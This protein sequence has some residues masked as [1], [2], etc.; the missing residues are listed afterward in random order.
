[1]LT[2]QTSGYGHGRAVVHADRGLRERHGAEEGV[3]LLGGQ[4][5]AR[6]RVP[7]LPRGHLHGGL[8]AGHLL[9]AHQP[10]VVV[11][12]AGQGQSVA[13]DGVGDETGRQVVV[14]LVEGVEDRGH[15]VAGQVGHERVQRVVIEPVEERADPVHRAEVA[16]EL[17]APGLPALERQRGVARVRA[18][19][20][21][22]SKRVAAGPAE[23]RFE[24]Q[25]V[26]EHDDAEAGG[27]KDVVHAAEEP[28]ADHGVEALAVVVDH[29][30]EV[31][32]VVLPALE[33]RLEHIALVE[34]GV[35]QHRDH[36]AGRRGRGRR[37]HQADV[38]LHERGEERHRHP[39]AHRPGGEV[40]AGDV[41]RAR[42][43]RLGAAE[44]AELLEV[45]ARLAPEEVLD[46]VVD[47]ARV[48]LHRH[49]VLGPQHVEVQR[50]QERAHRGARG[51]MA[52]HLQSVAARPQVIG[53]MDGPRRQPQHLALELAQDGEAAGIGV[54]NPR[55]GRRH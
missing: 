38:V 30:P 25:P 4:V 3:E 12:V 53:L 46:G 24:P 6:E 33:H 2:S 41:L 35:A 45:L 11:L 52:A 34:L 31:A 15:V 20:D 22:L 36:A 32:D 50:G 49:A 7:L 16:L 26:L 23:R 40:D 19:V 14:D 17:A 55:V 54:G 8:K 1:M 9:S 28:I 27:A 5:E 51:L 37:L 29:P 21:P 48:R 43:I 42:G 10:R 47:R 18:V 13:L 44:R 39:E